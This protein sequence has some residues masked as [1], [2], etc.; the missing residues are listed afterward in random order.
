MDRVSTH[1]TND[2]AQF[3]MRQRQVD[4]NE[5]QTRIA[6]QRRIVEL[7]DDPVAA[8]HG[9]RY[10]SVQTRLERYSDNL[11]YL[12]DNYRV[13]EGYVRSAVD[14]LQH[15][16]EL[17][18][19]GANG[20][21]TSTDR[22]AMAA[23]VD[24]V[25]EEL[26]TLANTRGPDGNSL[27]S[28]TETRLQPFREIRG[29]VPGADR[30]VITSVEYLGNVDQRQVQISDIESIPLNSP[31]NDIFWAERQTLTSAA[32]AVDYVVQQPARIFLGPATIELSPGDNI[33]TIMSRINSAGAG[34]E[35]RLDPVQ[36]SLVLEG[37]SPAQLWLGDEQGT[38]LADLGVIQ[39]GN[40]SP[41]D[42]LNPD[43]RVSGGSVFDMVI[44][45]RD[46]LYGNDQLEIG[47]SALQGIDNALS[48]VL[49]R[50]GRLGAQQSRVDV[51]YR[52]TEYDIP[53]VAA[54]ESRE[55]DLDMAEAI[56]E[57]QMLEYT[58][59]ASL[60]VAGRVLP[61]TLLDFLR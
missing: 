53:E 50:L 10:Q 51:A 17:A 5:Q 27:F 25:L 61:Q 15:V 42:N 8:A 14:I 48:H 40:N 3:F 58:H 31:G 35:A 22:A 28:G 24:Q 56:T 30:Q 6:T 36:R 4:L 13:Q 46:D 57:L 20:T 37:I 29:T 2:N 16:R 52:R 45:L 55:L 18:V 33:Y 1:Q 34:V 38:V 54:N 12:R 19:R 32:P 21:F 49:G 43:A 44:A 9:T 11:E 23:E 59:R 26:V 47:S 39:D 7:R 60:G 41:P